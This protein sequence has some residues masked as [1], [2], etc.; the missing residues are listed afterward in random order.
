[1]ILPHIDEHAVTIDASPAAVWDALLRVVERSF[2]SA[3]FAAHALGC[4]D[5]AARG[6][7]PLAVGSAI[8]GFHVVTADPPHELA[9]AGRHRFADYELI[10]RIDGPA[11]H[12]PDGHVRLRAESRAAFPGLTG[13][14]YRTLVIGTGGHVLGVRH[15]LVTVRRQVE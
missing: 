15:L 10:F 8:P 2:T 6:P 4:H 9:L 3:S 7:R 14:V 12:E 1:M 13:T 5:V 11:G